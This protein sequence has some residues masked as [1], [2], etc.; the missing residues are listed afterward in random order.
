MTD[1]RTTFTELT[2]RTDRIDDAELDAFWAT[3]APPPSS[4]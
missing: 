3:L 2:E 1:A 4:S